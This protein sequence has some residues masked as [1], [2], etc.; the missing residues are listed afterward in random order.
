MILRA[1]PK[2]NWEEGKLRSRGL[3]T[4]LIGKSHSASAATVCL[5]KLMNFLFFVMLKLLLLCSPP[6]GASMNM[7]TTGLSLFFWSCVLFQ[8]LFFSFFAPIQTSL[9]RLFLWNLFKSTKIIKLWD[10]EYMRVKIVL[11]ILGIGSWGLST[12]VALR[13]IYI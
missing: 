5:R 2:R 4:L 3:K 13:I 12:E 1:L 7:P 11:L 10:Y 6:G 8:P 9:Q